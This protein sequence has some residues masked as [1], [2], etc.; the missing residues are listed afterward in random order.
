ML[1]AATWTRYR[2]RQRSDIEYDVEV[3]ADGTPL[4]HLIKSE[5]YH[6]IRTIHNLSHHEEAH[7]PAYTYMPTERFL[8]VYEKTA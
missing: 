6:L 1:E 3:S 8:D 5:S 2:H 7:Q 4:T